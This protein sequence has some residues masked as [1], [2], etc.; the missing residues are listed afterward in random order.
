M[1]IIDEK[2]EFVPIFPVLSKIPF[3]PLPPAPTVTVIATPIGT[4]NPDSA[5]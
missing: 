4:A 5:R 2:I 3:P 1:E